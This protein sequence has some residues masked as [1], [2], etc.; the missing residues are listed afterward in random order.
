M[1]N[2]GV[3]MSLDKFYWEVMDSVVCSIVKSKIISSI[4]FLG[5]LSDRSSDMKW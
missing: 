1:S 2:K 5:D 4:G 3:P